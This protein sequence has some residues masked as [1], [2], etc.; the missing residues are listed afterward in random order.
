[1]MVLVFILVT[2][3]K[4]SVAQLCPTLCNPMDYSPPGSLSMGFPRKEY[5]S[6]LPLPSPGDLPDQGI[7]ST[8]PTLQTF[9]TIWATGNYWFLAKANEDLALFAHISSYHILTLLPPFFLLPVEQTF[10]RL[11]FNIYYNNTM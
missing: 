5:W 9:F 10:I 8:S 6:R 3:V 7:K 1:M 11:L 2:I 4:V